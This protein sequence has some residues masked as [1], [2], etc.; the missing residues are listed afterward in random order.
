MGWAGLQPSAKG[1]RMH[2]PLCEVLRLMPLRVLRDAGAR[3][4]VVLKITNWLA[5]CLLVTWGDQTCTSRTACVWDNFRTVFQGAAL[6][7]ATIVYTSVC[8]NTAA[9]AASSKR[10][11]AG[12]AFKSLYHL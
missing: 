3:V 11:A 1:I 9:F 6:P 2:Y 5:G 7:F 10:R 12:L 8:T 4:H